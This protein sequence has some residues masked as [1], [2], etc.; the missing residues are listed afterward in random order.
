M[1]DNNADSVV[2]PKGFTM[3]I[4]ARNS[5]S[6]PGFAI[7]YHQPNGDYLYFDNEFDY[8][9]LCQKTRFLEE[10]WAEMHSSSG[11]DSKDWPSWYA[12]DEG[13]HFI[14]LLPRC[15]DIYPADK[16]SIPEQMLTLIEKTYYNHPLQ[17]R[18]QLASTQYNR[19][20]YISSSGGSLVFQPMEA[21]TFKTINGTPLPRGILFTPIAD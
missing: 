5:G 7:V 12:S 15:I 8:L 13:R 9:L 10:T 21:N 16:I 11:A 6:V 14:S 17:Q 20:E 18:F 4:V 2:R 19:K 3:E 1:A